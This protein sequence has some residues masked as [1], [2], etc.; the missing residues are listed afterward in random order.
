MLDRR[1]VPLSPSLL[2]AL[3][4]P[5][6]PTPQT[7]S[8][9][10]RESGGSPSIPD[11]EGLPARLERPGLPRHRHASR[12]DGGPGIR[13]R[14]DGRHRLD[15]GHRGPL[16]VHG[17][18]LCAVPGAG[19]RQDPLLAATREAL[20][21][22]GLVPEGRGGAG[23]VEGPP[24]GPE[25]RAAPLADHGV[26]RRPARRLERQPLDPPRYDLGTG[27]PAGKRRI[28]VRVDNRMVVDVGRDSHSVSDHT[29]GNWNGIV[30]RDRAAGH[31]AGLRR[32][33]AGVSPRRRRV[34]SR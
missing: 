21:G 18:A 34:P 20:P 9:P 4:A 11:D 25:P 28:T 24:A 33:P 26:A 29:Q 8:S 13:R 32:R 22:R 17:A 27:V 6:A 10:W 7:G 15:R 1:V 30:G 3:A 23:G 12:G 31:G 2:V 19:E 5:A 16:L 14:G